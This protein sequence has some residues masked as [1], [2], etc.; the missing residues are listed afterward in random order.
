MLQIQQTPSSSVLSPHSF[1]PFFSSVYSS[2]LS[3]FLPSSPPPTLFALP[4]LLSSISHFFLLIL[5]ASPFLF[6]P[7]SPFFCFL[8]SWLFSEHVWVSDSFLWLF[9]VKDGNSAS[10][11]IASPTNFRL[12]AFAVIVLWPYIPLARNTGCFC[13]YFWKIL[14]SLLSL[15]WNFTIIR[16]KCLT[17]C[18]DF[19]HRGNSNNLIHLHILLSISRTFFWYF[20]LHFYFSISLGTFS[21]T[22]QVI[23]C[24]LWRIWLILP[25]TRHWENCLL[26]HKGE[27][28]PFWNY[29]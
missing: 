19:S 22:F 9:T 24:W 6:F 29:H 14:S 5:I 17:V 3:W 15:G 8:L 23:L 11:G 27:C 26:R 1:N 28:R 10:L 13:C 18:P 7:I 4:P 21:T 16:C 12:S 20:S 2:P 25:G